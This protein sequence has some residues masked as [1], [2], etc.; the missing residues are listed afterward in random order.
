MNIRKVIDYL[1]TLS[2]IKR[3]FT[4]E[5]KTY[6][7]TQDRELDGRLTGR[8]QAYQDVITEL[9]S[10]ECDIMDQERANEPRKAKETEPEKA[11]EPEVYTGPRLH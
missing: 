5:M 2:I 8:A 7:G 11:F 1:K 10:L 4:N 9:E 6:E 3:N